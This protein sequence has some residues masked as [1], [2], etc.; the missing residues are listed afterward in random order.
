MHLDFLPANMNLCLQGALIGDFTF[1][2]YYL[3]STLYLAM[4]YFYFRPS[5]F[6]TCFL[7]TW[8]TGL[9]CQ[10]SERQCTRQKQSAAILGKP[11]GQRETIW[12]RE[13]PSQQLKLLP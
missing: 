3:K 9:Y 2:K 11:Q 7:P 10:R 6:C 12:Q 5:I 13:A 1:S 4:C 8:V